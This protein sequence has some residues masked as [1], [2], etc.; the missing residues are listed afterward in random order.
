MSHC[1]HKFGRSSPGRS[2]PYFEKCRVSFFPDSLVKATE[3]SDKL[4]TVS[5]HKN[6]RRKVK[7]SIMKQP[8]KILQKTIS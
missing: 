7:C 6:V 2:L 3:I 8:M 5:E 4:N 1:A